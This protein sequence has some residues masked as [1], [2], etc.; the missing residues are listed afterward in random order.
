M[1]KLITLIVLLAITSP[2]YTQTIQIAGNV[3]TTNTEQ[4][5]RQ[6]KQVATASQRASDEAKDLIIDEE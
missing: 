2:I 3:V 1:I 4:V 6:T 5:T